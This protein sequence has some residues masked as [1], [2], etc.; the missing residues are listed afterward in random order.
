[1]HSMNYINSVGSSAGDTYHV[2]YSE[3]FTLYYSSN[4]YFVL[5][6]SIRLNTTDS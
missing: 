3:D 1:M 5:V 4:G 6:D 2:P